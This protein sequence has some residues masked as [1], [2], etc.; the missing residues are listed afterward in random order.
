M[1]ERKP[2]DRQVLGL[3]LALSVLSAALY[4]GWTAATGHPAFPLD[5]AW[6]H[7]TYARNL[8]RYG[9]FAYVPGQ[10]SAGSTAPLW[11]LLLTPP[12]LLGFD[13][14]LWT[15]A[16]GTGLLA[17]TGWMAYRLSRCLFPRQRNVALLTALFCVTEWH[18]VWA[19]LSGMETL[20]FI[21]LSL[22]LIQLAIGNYQV[23][24]RSTGRPQSRWVIG[25]WSLIIGLLGGLLT[26]TRPEGVGLVGLV[27]LS[28]LADSLRSTPGRQAG[29]VAR[30]GPLLL[31]ALGFG[32]VMAPYVAFNLTTTGF[33]F[34][35]TFYAKQAEYRAAIVGV[36]LA[37][38]LLRVTGVTLVGAQVLL[39][40]GFVVAAVGLLQARRWRAMLPLAWWAGFLG[41]YAL[42]LPVTYQYGRYLIP[43]IPFFVIYGVAGTA[44]LLRPLGKA[45]GGPRL[46]RV[47]AR[48]VS[49]AVPIA[50]ATLVVAFWAIGAREYAESTGFI[51]GEMV[52]V[53]HWLNTNTPPGSLIAVH[54]I[55]AVG[56]FTRRPLLDLAGLITPEVIPFIT[57][58]QGLL[59]FMEEHQASYAVF[60]PDWSPAY[61]RMARDPRLRPVYRTG[62]AWTRQQGRANMTVYE[63]V[64]G[65]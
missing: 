22:W 11:T 5:D 44:S 47:L 57:D 34:P 27:G 61:A 45:R 56:Y 53:A 42:R 40:P 36:P 29:R 12:Y 37:R 25:R 60:F 4:L 65:E 64:R 20:L 23:S 15:Y 31:V 26:L 18:L 62:Y 16:L 58:E 33:L 54:D 19:A 46:I 43:T 35:N 17:L 10:P 38:R 48:A 50:V 14:K 7:Q 9:Q 63:L 51:E 8:V 13:F 59:A 3:T 1:S 49:R 55:G 28:L 41:V 21:F 52:T 30:L 2:S 24:N 39:L 6:I 32:L